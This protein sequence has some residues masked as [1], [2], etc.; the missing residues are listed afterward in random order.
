MY[1]KYGNIVIYYMYGGS[2]QFEE[3]VS[4]SNF[5][6]PEVTSQL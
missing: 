2:K 5:F 3:N 4:K 1:T 6:I